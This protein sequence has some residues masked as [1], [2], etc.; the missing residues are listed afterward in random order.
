MNFM[1]RGL[2]S[3][4]AKKGR[5]LILIA[6]FSAILIFVLAGL[7]IKS[8]ADTATDT[9][10]KS[11]G[12][13]VTLSTNREQMFKKDSDS[14]DAS[15]ESTSRPDPG[16]FQMT[17]VNLEDAEKIAALDGVKSYS[18]E[19]STS[20]T[21]GDDIEP[22]S[23]SDEEDTTADSATDDASQGANGMP[24]GGMMGG[25][26]G[27]DQGDFQI[28][29]VLESAAYSSFSAGTATLTSGEALTA[30][31]VDTNNVLI[32]SALAEANDLAVG[33]TFTLVDANDENVEVTIK[34]IYETSDTGTSMG[35]QFNFMNPANTIFSAYTLANTIAGEEGDTID[36]AVY[37][38]ADPNEMDSFVKEA[39]SLI[40][41]D[42]F[43]LQTNDQ[44]YQQMLTPLNN[45]SSF[46]KNIIILVAAAGVIILTLIVM[47]T[48]RERRYEIG[49]LLSLGEARGKVILQFFTEI[50]VCMLLALGIASASGNLVGNVVG[51]QLLEQQT[52][53]TA[54]A[55]QG[56]PGGEGQ[57]QAPSGGRGQ[58]GP[59]QMISSTFSQSEEIKNLDITVSG[60]QI[61]LL[62]AIGLGIS[63]VS[64]LLSSAG[65]MRLNP[66]KIL[67]S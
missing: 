31:D 51:N 57:G 9:A 58:G 36:S 30:E 49:V 8:A 1:K 62:A 11:V 28:T 29:G 32:E 56:A 3:L 53:Q 5:S 66:K 54:S 47:M 64:I 44:M 14:D 24:G 35:M 55:D 20:A 37:T 59:G 7:T 21:K 41:T 34:G 4:W 17:P 6:V 33:D 43:S 61:A 25:A 2:Q 42:T 46:A 18:F 52:T 22:I 39:E 13:T 50:F 15:D 19:V 38:L 63:F 40:D 23:S 26:G 45:V 65:I 12:A 10:K 27:M 48:I 60:E 67:I 16:S